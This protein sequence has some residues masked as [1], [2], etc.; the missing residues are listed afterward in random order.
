MILEFSEE[1]EYYNFVNRKRSVFLKEE[2][3]LFGLE[4]LNLNDIDIL[5]K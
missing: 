1:V 3:V 2:I 5:E 4:K